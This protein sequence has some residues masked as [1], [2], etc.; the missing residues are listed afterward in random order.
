[1]KKGFVL[2]LILASLFYLFG[3]SN[4]KD[5]IQTKEIKDAKPYYC[6][7][8]NDEDNIDELE[9]NYA[10]DL[11]NECIR[12]VE[13]YYN[14]DD[15]LSHIEGKSDYL[16]SLSIDSEFDSR[17]SSLVVAYEFLELALSNY[18]DTEVGNDGETKYQYFMRISKDAMEDV[19]GVE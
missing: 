8:N 16:Q 13:E 3:C 10:I 4:K 5:E 14:A 9:Y 11:Y 19:K 1:M 12:S 7:L 17:K 18:N 2:L 15:V 6:P